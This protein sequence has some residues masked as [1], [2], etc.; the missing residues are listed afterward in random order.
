MIMPNYGFNEW[1][2]TFFYAEELFAAPIH[3]GFV[4]LGWSLFFLIPLAFQL[5]THMAHLIAEVTDED[6]NQA[7]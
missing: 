7:A 5:I 1:G 2:H 6:Y 3:W 4:F